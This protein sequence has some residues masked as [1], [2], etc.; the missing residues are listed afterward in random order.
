[1]TFLRSAIIPVVSLTLS[2]SFP[3]HAQTAW[4]LPLHLSDS[5]TD[6]RYHYSMFG[7]PDT[8]RSQGVRGKAW[9]ADSDLRSVRAQLVVP[10]PSLNFQGF[11]AFKMLGGM[12]NGGVTPPVT[13]SVENIAGLCHPRDILLSRPCLPTMEGRVQFG[14]MVRPF[15]LPVRIERKK[16]YFM[17]AGE[18]ELDTIAA[19]R[20]S[21]LGHVVDSARFTFNI[22][23]PN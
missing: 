1:M 3:C 11:D 7:R 13:V 10:T 20:A 6:V 23:I 22:K 9:L 18:G 19:A 2:M 21:S 5:N 4:K 14:S 15:N 12:F 8:G 16:G 17:L